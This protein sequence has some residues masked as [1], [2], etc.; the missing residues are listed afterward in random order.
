MSGDPFAE[1]AAKLL[2][3]LDFSAEA[4]AREQCHQEEQ[5]AVFQSL[6]AVMDAFDRL[7]GGPAGEGGSE[8]GTVPLRTVRLLARQLS[9]CLERAG[10]VAVPC[11]G[12]PADP[13]VHEIVEVRQTAEVPGDT[14]VEVL[15]AGYLWNG[16][17]LRR[18]RVIVACGEKETRE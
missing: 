12:E 13:A 1:Q 5:A 7:L 4:A 10:V 16:R 6:L 2:A 3:A 15:S 18:P 8:E 9:R 11:L 17:P 14:I